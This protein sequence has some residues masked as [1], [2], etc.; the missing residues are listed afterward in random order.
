MKPLALLFLPLAALAGM[1]VPIELHLMS[2]C[3]DATVCLRDL[4]TPAL[5]GLADIS[6]VRLT[7]IG[8]ATSGGGVS[9]P[10]GP[11]ECLGDMLHLCGVALST[12]PSPPPAAAYWDFTMCLFSDYS[13]V[14]EKEFVQHCAAK[15]K[16]GWGFD[17]LNRCA[18]DL[19]PRGGAQLLRESVER[20]KETGVRASC[21]VRVAGST[22]CV[23]DGGQWK[24]CE[25]GSR[26]E[27]LVRLVRELY[28][29]ETGGLL[30]QEREVAD[31]ERR[32]LKEYVEQ[33]GLPKVDRWMEL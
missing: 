1:P 17:E 10:H 22:V 30:K 25:R 33:E 16:A 5:P 15:A 7:F 20:T 6:T 19:G 13:R 26:P 8:N 14:C 4:I 32:S 24:Q 31:G 11:S 28:E 29:A 9:C 21:T 12:P 23:R 2:Q 18:S 3:P 27:D